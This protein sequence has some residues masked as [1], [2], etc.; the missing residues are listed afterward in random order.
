MNRPELADFDIAEIHGV[1]TAE[2]TDRY[3]HKLGVDKI[4]VQSV[5]YDPEDPLCDYEKTYW[6]ANTNGA[7]KFFGN[8]IVGKNHHLS[9]RQIEEKVVRP[10]MPK[11]FEMIRALGEYPVMLVNGHEPDLQAALSIYAANIAMSRVQ[12][13]NEKQNYRNAVNRAHGFVARGFVPIRIGPNYGP[14]RDQRSL[15]RIMQ[16]GAGSHFTFGVTKQMIASGIPKDF[17]KVYHT[18][19]KSTA[20]EIAHSDTYDDPDR[21]HTFWSI[22]P[23]GTRDEKPTEGEHEG[24]SIMPTVIPATIDLI[25]SMNI[26]LLP[27]YFKNGRGK[28]ETV[29]QV[30][31]I[32]PPNEV[33]DSTVPTI[34]ADLA[35][36]RRRNGETNAFYEEELAA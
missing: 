35:E 19:M 14:L 31:S 28:S 26:G 20:I 5:P 27:F 15:P 2:F 23:S 13:G 34:M 30:G 36:F 9:K 7:S 1:L 12:E 33:T 22:S 16:L 4:G 17:A 18:G 25:K 24:K 21:L 29:A 10:F 3:L 11:T 32:I 8:L 6:P